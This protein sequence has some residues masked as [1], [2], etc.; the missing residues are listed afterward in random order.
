[1]RLT[2]LLIAS[3]ILALSGTATAAATSL[4]FIGNSFLYGYGSAVRFYRTNT[5]TDLNNGGIGG[6]PALLKSCTLQADLDYDLSLETRG[7]S[8]LHFHLN[9]K[10]G[11]MGRRGWDKVV[12]HGYS[13]L[14]AEKPR[15]PAK[16]ITTAKRM[17]EFLRARNPDVELY[18]L[19]T[20]SLAD[21]T[22]VENGAWAGT[23]IDQ[24]GRDVRAAFDKAA[25][26]AD[27][28]TYG[29]RMHPNDGRV[30]SNFIVQALKGE[31]ITIYGDGLQTRSFC[32]VDDLIDGLVRMMNN[33]QDLVG[34][35]NIGNPVEFSMRELAE[36]V[37]KLTG[38]KSKVVYRP[39]PSDDPKQRRP[40]ISLATSKLGWKP[41]IELENGLRRTIE[42]FSSSQY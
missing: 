21:Q 18:L 29:P 5:V 23:P 33:D 42:Y 37:T 24:M 15:D 16:L 19:A 25:A 26:V 8:G 27:A 20:W 3:A 12:M 39:L 11:V 17:A 10:L 1:M 31:N 34:P 36:R 22:Y 2:S 28:N 9:E 41:K 38:S 6:V 40:D 35:V 13:T 4:L 7:G 32:Y 14:D 30:V